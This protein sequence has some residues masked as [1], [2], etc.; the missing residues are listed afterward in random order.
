MENMEKQMIGEVELYRL[1]EN[2]ENPREI[3]EE[4]FGLLVK[5]VL[6]FPRMLWLAPIVYDEAGVVLGGNMRLRALNAISDMDDAEREDIIKQDKRLGD[7]QVSALVTYWQAWASEKAPRVPAVCADDLTE[8]QKK[9]FIIKHNASFGK[10]DF[11]LLAN[12]WSGLPL[13]DWAIDVWQPME[14]G[15]DSEDSEKSSMPI[16]EDNFDEESIEIKKRCSYGDLWQLGEHRLMCGDSTDSASVALLM[17]GQK[18]DM[19]FTDPP[20]GVSIGDKNKALNSVQKAGCCT[21]NIANDNISVDDLY[22]ILVKAMTNCRENCKDCACYYVTSPQG[23]ELGLMMMMMK[24][25]GLPVRHMLIWEKNSAT[26]S[27]GRLDYDYQHEPIFYTWTK[28]HKNYRK[29]EFR[30]T[31]WKYDKPRKCDLHP[32]MKPVELVANCMMDASVEGDIVLDMFGGSGT[33]IIAAEQ[34]GRKARLMELDPHYCD[35][36]IT[37]WEEYTGKEAVKIM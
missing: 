6:V 16:E 12:E 4:K 13:N 24:D 21:E 36:I 31:I 2:P 8:E 37:R 29:G 17:G 34:L 23:G 3:S 7:G 30:T 27:L 22:P 26:F 33:T 14:M 19:V 20:Y 18:A 28:S 15:V 35:V 32:T 11:D 5:S 25:A 1:R 10:W 9:E